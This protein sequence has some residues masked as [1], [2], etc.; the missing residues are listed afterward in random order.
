MG[1]RFGLWIF[2]LCRLIGVPRGYFPKVIAHPDNIWQWLSWVF[3]L[4]RHSTKCTHEGLNYWHQALAPMCHPRPEKP[5]HGL[6]IMASAAVQVILHQAKTGHVVHFSANTGFQALWNH[7]GRQ[8]THNN[9]FPP[10]MRTPSHFGRR[11][12]SPLLAEKRLQEKSTEQTD[13]QA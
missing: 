3:V 12:G 1:D 4:R 5:H 13:G 7:K 6:L 11:K 9:G 8:R 2:Y 10:I